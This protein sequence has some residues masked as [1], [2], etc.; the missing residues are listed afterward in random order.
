MQ[1]NQPEAS[2]Q[3]QIIDA[4]HYAGWLV[5][6]T[7]DSRRSAPGFPDLVLAHVERGVAF[8]E[9]KKQGGRPTDEQKHWIET[10]TKAGHR[11]T[12]LWPEDLDWLLKFLN[13]GPWT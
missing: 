3:Q 8:L 7:Y 5:Y 11:A 2:F 13:G 4:A 9:L 12:V 6:H 1:K 10:L